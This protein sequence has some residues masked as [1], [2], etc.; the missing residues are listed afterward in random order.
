MTRTLQDPLI[1]SEASRALKRHLSQAARVLL[2]RANEED[3]SVA[4]RPL[5]ALDMG[6]SGI[7]GL[8][9]RGDC[10]C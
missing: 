3:E 7:C 10:G 8:W 5:V 4:R 6:G 2:L 9:N 1:L